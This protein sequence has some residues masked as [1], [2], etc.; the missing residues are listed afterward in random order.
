MSVT[1]YPVGT[2][3]YNPEKCYNG[4]TIMCFPAGPKITLL[5]DMNGKIVNEWDVQA[6]R[7]RLL[8]SG[9]LLTVTGRKG[10]DDLIQEYD[11]NHRLVWE[12]VPP[13]LP[14]HDVQR[15]ENGNTLVLYSEVVPEKYRQKIQS[16][17]RRRDVCLRADVV[18]EVTPKKETVWEWHAYG[19]LDINLYCQVANLADWTHINTIQALPENKWYDGGDKRFKPGNIL[20]SPRS[21]GRIFIVDKESK[22]IVWVYTGDY[23][24]GLAGQHEPHMIEKGLP[25]AG[26][27]LIFDNGTPPLNT[28]KHSGQSY[29]LEINPHLK[30]IVW[31]Y[32]NG[33]KFFSAYRSSAQRLPNGNTL[34]CES[35]GPRIFELTP[36]REIT[37]EYAVPYP[38]VI[39]RAYRYPYDW[40]AQ[41]KALEKPKEKQVVPPSHVSTKPISL[42]ALKEDMLWDFQI[43]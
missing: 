21:L 8:R 33:E 31:K 40:C 38:I 1:V 37:W 32:E 18:L 2:T 34:I 4:Y 23:D 17:R 15:L 22:D 42:K 30:A 43:K 7:A 9:N 27:I 41:L 14:H 24:G 6:L 10:F 26:N 25:G 16:F 39:G 19:H 12:Y 28:L 3:V 29:V 13:G 36:E 20:I 35:E 11:W 5:V